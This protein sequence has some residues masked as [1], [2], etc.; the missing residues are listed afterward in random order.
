MLKSSLKFGLARLFPAASRSICAASLSVL[1]SAHSAETPRRPKAGLFL[2]TLCGTVVLLLATAAHATTFDVVDLSDT[3]S[4]PPTGSLRAALASAQPGDT[5]IFAV[6]G[7]IALAGPLPAIA[8]DLTITG[9]GASSL[10]ISGNSQYGVFTVSSGTVSI[11]GLTIATANRSSPGGAIFNSGTLT[12]TNVL[13][14]QDVATSGGAI[15]NTGTLTVSGSSF[16]GN[17]GATNGGAIL[18][19]SGA[20][21]ATVT[22]SFFLNNSASQGNTGGAIQ[23]SGGTLVVGNNTFV[24]NSAPGGEGGAIANGGTLTL[25]NNTFVA[26]TS[27]GGA[28]GAIVNSGGT[29]TLSNNILSGNGSGTGAGVDRTGGTVNAS[30]DVFYQNLDSGGAESDCVSCNSNL[31]AVDADPDL[32]PLG[33]YGGST[34]TMMP[35]PGS[36]AI[37]AGS[38]AQFPSGETTDQRRFPVTDCVDAG[39]VQTNYA[40]VSTTADSGSGSLRRALGA[41]IGAGV[42]I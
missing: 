11:S 12:V 33:N 32:A 22:T 39:A 21:T 25:S 28:G 13:F 18:N 24:G 41:A 1:A 4:S 15:Y 14:N 2:R 3:I 35:L 19:N 20:N 38:F 40:L 6:T 26:N 29:L 7:T 16:L 10:T 30:D 36:P 31:G 34:E 37:C 5:I 42:G 27:T 9:P 17:S 8:A 23:N